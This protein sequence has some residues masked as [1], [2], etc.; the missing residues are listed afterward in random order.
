[1]G[2]NEPTDEELADS[3]RFTRVALAVAL[4]GLVSTAA[5]A[6]LADPLH[7]F[8]TG[9]IV[10]M[11]TSER[12]EKPATFLERRPPPEAI[13]LGS[14]RVMKLSPACLREL[15]GLPAY[16]FGVTDAQ[17][18]DLEAILGFVQSR[19]AVPLRELVIGI[20]VEAFDDRIEVDPRL[21][22]ST[23]LRDYVPE[24]HLSWDAATRALFGWQAFR[25]GLT[26]LRY[27]ITGRRPHES[28]HYTPEGEIVYDDERSDESAMR[29]RRAANIQRRTGKL[30][31]EGFARLSPSRL[32]LFRDLVTSAKARG[33]NVHVFVPPLHR[34][35]VDIRNRGPVPARLAD[36]DRFLRALDVEH[37]IEYLAI[38]RVEDVGGDP[39]GYYDG[40]HMTEANAT[41]V[42]LAMFHREHGCGI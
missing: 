18:E 29:E 32:E 8:G 41:R 7:T 23:L 30:V 3:V 24:S 26:S 17:V 10:S 2:P 11:L 14:S 27:A 5:I 16:N 25:Y 31:A 34:E 33:T 13:V 20:D 38:K 12:D 1:M 15:T 36:L 42:L 9:R 19:A 4:V 35:L 39:E 6:I 21:L 28:S 40:N 37:V 22:S